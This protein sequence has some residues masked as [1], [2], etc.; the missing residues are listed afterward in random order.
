MYCLN[1][2]AQISE[3]DRFCPECGFATTQG[4]A[5]VSPPQHFEQQDPLP[6]RPAPLQPE[7]PMTWFK[8]LANVFLILGAVGSIIAAIQYIT[9]ARYLSTGVDADWIYTYYPGFQAVDIIMG[10]FSAA[11]AAFCFYTRSQLLKFRKGS[12]KLI[13]YLYAANAGVTVIAE[14]CYISIISANA[15]ISDSDIISSFISDTISA[16]IAAAI[17][18]PVNI[19]YFKKRKHLFVN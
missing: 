12:P 11:Y 3:N 13:T 10:I 6:Y 5:S 1:C 19:V 8:V 14:I 9:G 15:Y 16:I 18:I 17:M 7:L 2:G 4:A